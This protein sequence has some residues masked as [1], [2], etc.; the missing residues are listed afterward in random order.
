MVAPRI[1]CK[2]DGLIRRAKSLL[3]KLSAKCV[4]LLGGEFGELGWRA[5]VTQGVPTI[6][7][8]QK[9]VVPKCRASND[10]YSLMTF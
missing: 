10:M 4:S 6:S 7:D 8:V 3:K 2:Y 1:H 9:D 5:H